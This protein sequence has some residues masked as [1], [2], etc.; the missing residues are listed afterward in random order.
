MLFPDIKRFVFS[1]L[2]EVG[3]A[4]DKQESIGDCMD[5][6][7]LQDV[8]DLQLYSSFRTARNA[9]NGTEHSVNIALGS[10]LTAAGGQVF[11]GGR[12]LFWIEHSHT[13]DRV[14]KKVLLE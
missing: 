6:E 12:A 5:I 7:A 8:I 1:A 2:S 10:T 4:V 9:L 14:F 13:D 11:V 3:H